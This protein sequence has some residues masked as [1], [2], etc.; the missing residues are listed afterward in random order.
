MSWPKEHK[1]HSDAAKS[2]WDNRRKNTR[3]ALRTHHMRSKWAQKTD[4]RIKA[5]NPLPLT[6]KNID[7]WANTPAHMD[8]KGIDTGSIIRKVKV[9]RQRGITKTQ[10][11]KAVTKKI[12]SITRKVKVRKSLHK[13]PTLHKLTGIELENLYKI[14]DK[15]NVE[16]DLIDFKAYI[17]K[18]LD[19]HENKQILTEYISNIGIKAEIEEDI[20]ALEGQYR[21]YVNELKW[22]AE[23]LT[24]SVERSWAV[25][26]L[27][28]MT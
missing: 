4:E 28:A 18:T 12:E 2:G 16:K 14:A 15:F 13:Y 10:E 23:N 25:Q 9:I 21:N 19:Y 11:K 20:G 27:K 7:K 6:K 3:S 17:D 5:K 8:L 22:R 24:N 1:R 26:E